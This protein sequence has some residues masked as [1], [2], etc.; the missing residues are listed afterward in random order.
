LSLVIIILEKLNELELSKNKNNWN[1]EV[2]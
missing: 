2:N 1:W